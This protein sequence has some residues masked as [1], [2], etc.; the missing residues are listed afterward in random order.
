LE[1]YLLACTCRQLS[2]KHTLLTV[3]V[4]AFAILKAFY[5]VRAQKSNVFADETKYFSKGA[6]N[7]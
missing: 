5:H 1:G 7:H 3:F 2:E 4:K 6:K